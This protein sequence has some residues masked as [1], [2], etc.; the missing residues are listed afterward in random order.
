[1][2]EQQATIGDNLPYDAAKVADFADA[3]GAWLDKGALETTE[4]AEKLNDYITGCRGL[5]KKLDDQRSAEKKPHWDAG[6]AVDKLYKTPLATLTTAGNRVKPLLTAWAVKKAEAEAKAKREAEEAAEAERKAAEKEALEAESR[7]DVAGE[8][9]AA[10]RLK[11]ADKAAKQ[12]ART[13]T[14]G[15]VASATGGG[16][17]AAL[18]TYYT[19]E[20]TGVKM[21]VLWA[22]GA[23]LDDVEKFLLLLANGAKR[24]DA[25]L[26]IPGIKFIKDRRI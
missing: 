9:E 14:T 23:H 3:A 26:E 18:R 10:E 25:T 13:T 17:T 15:R 11:D 12:A 16:R 19:A 2:N 5:W 4:Q 22:L 20:I 24:H 21:A 6:Q 7:H 8:A 1:M